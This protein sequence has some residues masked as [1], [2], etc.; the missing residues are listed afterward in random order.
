MAIIIPKIAQIKVA[1]SNISPVI[2]GRQLQKRTWDLKLWLDLICMWALVVCPSPHNRSRYT[3]ET[4]SSLIV[5]S[6]F[7]EI[8]VGS[9]GGATVAAVE[10]ETQDGKC[11]LLILDAFAPGRPWRQVVQKL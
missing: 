6:L 9:D 7:S 10:R 3:S 8:H 11:P 2:T 4:I 1:L 5:S